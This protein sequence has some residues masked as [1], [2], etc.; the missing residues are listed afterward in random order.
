VE[1]S[2]FERKPVWTVTYLILREHIWTFQG[3]DVSVFRW[4]TCWKAQSETL[5]VKILRKLNKY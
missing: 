5:Q 1:E 2:D 4:K 3:L